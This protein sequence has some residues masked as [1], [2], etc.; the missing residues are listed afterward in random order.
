MDS[1]TLKSD[2]ND[3]D[4]FKDYTFGDF[5]DAND[6]TGVKVIVAVNLMMLLK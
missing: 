3:D 1:L 4:G 2:D 5:D 6:D